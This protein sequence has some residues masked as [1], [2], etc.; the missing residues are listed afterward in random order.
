M[1]FKYI[2]DMT[3]LFSDDP[4]GEVPD[5]LLEFRTYLGHIIKAATVTSDVEFQSAIPCRKK[6]NRK[7]CPGF[8]K[9]MKQE[10]P[11][12]YIYWRCSGCDDGGRIAKWRGSPY[13]QAQFKPHSPMDDEPNPP[14]EVE[15]TREE[16]KALLSA[17]FYDPDSERILYTARPVAQRIVLRGLY[18]D[19]DNFVGFIASDANHEDDKK[20]KKLIDSVYDK[21]ESATDKAY[22]DAEMGS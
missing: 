22:V 10:L 13:D 14:V 7:P 15:V 9:V 6:L 4:K 12:S 17:G 21:V 20:R 11:E 16:M 3:H 19:M 2:T 18:G 5:E 8:M 1:D